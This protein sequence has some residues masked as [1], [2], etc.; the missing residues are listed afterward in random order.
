MIYK[1][2]KLRVTHLH[3]GNSSKKQR[4]K[5]KYVTLCKVLT[6]HGNLVTTVRSQCNH[7]DTPSRKKG[8]TIATDRAKVLVDYLVQL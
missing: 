4:R 1:G 7:D 3:P 6:K 2:Y 8:F 5:S